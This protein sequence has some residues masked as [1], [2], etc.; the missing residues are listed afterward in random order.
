M[1]LSLS[2]SL[3]LCV[4]TVAVSGGI[5]WFVANVRSFRKLRSIRLVHRVESADRWYDPSDDQLFGLWCLVQSSFVDPSTLY[6]AAESVLLGV[7]AL[8]G[9][10]M[11]IRCESIIMYSIILDCGSTTQF[12]SPVFLL[13]L[14]GNRKDNPLPSILVISSSADQDQA[15]SGEVTGVDLMSPLKTSLFGEVS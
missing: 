8:S 14:F 11:S 7:L 6:P 10:S 15:K 13:I 1:K 4:S 3:S 2:L 12:N 9:S 5:A